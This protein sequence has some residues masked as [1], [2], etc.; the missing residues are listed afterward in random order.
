MYVHLSIQPQLQAVKA[1]MGSC[2]RYPGTGSRGTS[3]TAA[4]N[5]K[6]IFGRSTPNREGYRSLQVDP[7]PQNA[8]GLWNPG[9]GSQLGT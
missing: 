2:P 1:T 9:L 6:T 7:P 8:G 3:K 5:Q 4:T